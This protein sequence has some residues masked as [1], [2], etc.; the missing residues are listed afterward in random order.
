MAR[1]GKGKIILFIII[2][3]LL[4]FGTLAI[5][6]DVGGMKGLALS[7]VGRD[8]S[9][10]TIAVKSDLEIELEKEKEFINAE[11]TKL[12]ALRTDL[13]NY[14]AQ[15]NT[16]EEELDER[17]DE[18]LEKEKEVE[19][20]NNRLTTEFEDLNDLIKI[21]EKM[22]GEEAAAILSQIENT[23]Q[24]ILIIKNLKKEKSAEILGLMDSKK[25][26]GLLSRMY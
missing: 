1:K 10:Q 5:V 7:L 3:F 18:L 14:K 25:A 24:V 22:D 23:D 17:E 11:K 4:I 19:G 21:Y 8:H 26:A 20:L 9:K 16:R 12:S 15:L 13:E 2:L 6:F